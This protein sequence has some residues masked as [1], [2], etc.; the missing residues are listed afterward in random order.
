MENT[1]SSTGLKIALG[2]ALALFLGTIFYT[3]K[4]YNEKKTNEAQLQDEKALVMKDLNAMA[5]QYDVAIGENKIANDRLI[6]AKDRIHGLMDSLKVSETN[7]RSLWRYKKKFLSLQEEMD[8]LLAE[9]DKLKV[10]NKLLATSLDSTRVQLE[11]RTIFTDSLLTQ[12]TELATVV[13]DAAALGVVGLKGFGVKERTSG[14]LVPM[15]RA[16]RVDKI[17]VCYTVPKNKLT[18]SGNKEFYVQ[19]IGPGDLVLG[20]N[21]QIVF[22]DT[23][24]TLNYSMVSKFN[25]ENSSLDVC[26]FATASGDDKFEKGSYTVNVFDQNELIATNTFTLK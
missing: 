21:A 22:Q 16:S 13:E 26:E 5:E 19:V 23:N 8:V 6:D 12:N 15:G 18:E 9:N 7:V 4:L 11:E 10:E 25:Y 20:E 14:K 3:S 2:I 24:K 1:K 17:R